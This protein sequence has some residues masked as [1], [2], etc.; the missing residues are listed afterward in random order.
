MVKYLAMSAT[1]VASLAIADLA[2]ARGRHGCASCNVSSGCPGGVCSVTVAPSKMAIA[3]GKAAVI[4]DAP[5]AVVGAPAPAPT[6]DV[7]AA[8]PAPRT[9]VNYTGRRGRFGW[10][11]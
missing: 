5:P 8:Q 7:A 2:E 1:L 9:Y 6:A 4:G 11:R 3:P 10:R